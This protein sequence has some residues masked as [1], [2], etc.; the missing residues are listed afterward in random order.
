[1]KKKKIE[2]ISRGQMKRII[3]Q[4]GHKEDNLAIISINDTSYE[5]DEMYRLL[6]GSNFTIAAFQDSDGDDG[7]TD[8][9]AKLLLSFIERNHDKNFL[10]H[11]FMGISRS[12]AV[13]KFINEFYECGIFYLED[14]K[15][16]NR[17]V[18]NK[19]QAAAGMSLAAYYEELEKHDRMVK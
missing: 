12:G 11:C 7:I 9:Q 16:Y 5:Y 19:L 3:S 4:Q 13:A 8:I 15:G 6:D 18:F 17:R 14:Y 10:I 2:F 1:M